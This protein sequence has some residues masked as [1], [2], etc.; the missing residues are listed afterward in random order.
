LQTDITEGV[1]SPD[2]P[3][4]LKSRK[5]F[6]IFLGVI[7]ISRLIILT[8]IPEHPQNFLEVDSP[9][10]TDP[11]EALI[12]DGRYNTEPR[13]DIPETL[14]PP[15]YPVWL[16]L[17]FLLFGNSAQAVVYFQLLLFLGTLALT[18][19]L[20]KKMFGSRPAWA[21]VILL[22]LDPSS[23]SYTFKVLTETLSAF[24]TIL[25]AY[26]AF[27]FYQSK[28]KVYFGVGA[29]LSLALVTLVRPTTYYF[30]PLL[31]IAFA[32]FLFR[33]KMGWKKILTVLVFTIL[34]LLVLVGGWQWRNLETA[35]MFRLASVQGWA[36][37]LGKG[38]QIYSEKHQTS[39]NDS[40]IALI[41]KL[42]QNH[43]DWSQMSMEQLDDVYLAEGWKLVREN[44]GLAI[45]THVLHMF[46]FF[47]APGTTS[48]F[49]RTFDPEFK[50]MNFN[51]YQ[52]A[53]YFEALLKNYKLF[54]VLML[55]G[56]AYLATMYAGIA[57]WMAHSWRDPG[58]LMWKGCHVFF[59]LLILY[60]AGA[61]SINYGQ[62][63]YRVVVMPLL[64]MY[65]GAGFP[66][67]LN[68]L[69]A[70]KCRTKK[71]V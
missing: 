2:P 15:G 14:R 25:F 4:A 62:D 20:T 11:A 10:Y 50:I 42:K 47:M 69:R 53:E 70:L 43:P 1:D 9:S 34:P 46:Y 23:L 58:A 8:L 7:L 57:S 36:L 68:Y 13:S 26:C 40:E 44:P 54:L 32:V 22:S 60:I 27:G 61:S 66:A 67:F 29:G 21:A 38:A 45:K 5:I 16:A 30:I 37:Y 19:A 51:W 24:L 18:F 63:R 49:F 39:L 3:D 41:Q 48:A 28:G 6:W 35:G 33:E 64:C 31:V 65:A 52:K 12:V 17:I 56:A 59:L 55:L 71:A